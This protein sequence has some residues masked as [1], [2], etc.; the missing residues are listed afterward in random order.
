MTSKCAGE[1]DSLRLYARALPIEPFGTSSTL[2]SC[3]NTSAN[4]EQL[5]G[6]EKESKFQLFMRI[7]EVC[8]ECDVLLQQKAKS[9]AS[10][11]PADSGEEP[12]EYASAPLKGHGRAIEKV[13]RCYDGSCRRLIDV[14]V[15]CACYGCA[16][17]IY[18]VA[19][20]LLFVSL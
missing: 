4:I 13:W 17:Y 8:K 16:R 3:C 20:Q 1:L 15:S 2:W 14:S 7:F 11:I 10:A 6:T 9:W 19:Y 12:P 5:V 18:S